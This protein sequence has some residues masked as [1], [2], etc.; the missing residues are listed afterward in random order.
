MEECDHL[1]LKL[2]NG[3][4]YYGFHSSDCGHDPCVVKCLHCGLT[5]AYIEMDYISREIEEKLRWMNPRYDA[6]IKMND[7]VFKRQYN[8]GYRRGGK[9]FDERVFNLISNEPLYLEY[10]LVIYKV[11]KEI[12]PNADNEELFSI[13]KELKSLETKEDYKEKNLEKIINTLLERY[14]DSKK[15]KVLKYEKK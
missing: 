5:N 11:A 3:V 10:P 6:F 13:M 4:D 8:H 12:N 1:F 15:V 2:R 9:S 7:K 14:N